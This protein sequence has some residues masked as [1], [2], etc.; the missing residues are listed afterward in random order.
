M[1][2]NGPSKK[3]KTNKQVK[4]NLQANIK[5]RNTVM[6]TPQASRKK[7]ESKTLNIESAT[8]DTIAET[9][10]FVIKGQLTPIK[11]TP[12]PV[13]SA[14]KFVTKRLQKARCCKIKD[15]KLQKSNPKPYLEKNELDKTSIKPSSARLALN[16]ETNPKTPTKTITVDKSKTLGKAKRLTKSKN[17]KDLDSSIKQIIKKYAKKLNIKNDKKHNVKTKN[18]ENK[19]NTSNKVVGRI[20]KAAKIIEPKTR[21][22]KQSVTI[23]GTS[24][25]VKPR[26]KYVKRKD[27]LKDTQKGKK[28]DENIQAKNNEEKKINELSEILPIKIKEEKVDEC[29]PVIVKVEADTEITCVQKNDKN[30]ISEVKLEAAVEH[31]KGHEGEVTEETMKSKSKLTKSKGQRDNKKSNTKKVRLVKKKALVSKKSQQQL[32]DKRRAKLLQFWNS[33]KRHRVASLNAI[34]KVHCLYENESKAAFDKMAENAIIKKE[35]AFGDTNGQKNKQNDTNEGT[36][37]FQS[38]LDSE[39]DEES[40][41]Q[42]VKRIL[43]DVPG[44]RAVG[45]HWDM[46]DSISSDNNSDIEFYR[47]P[48]KVVKVKKEVVPKKVEK[49]EKPK[50]T[51]TEKQKR[52]RKPKPEV[53][54]D[55]KD[56]VVKKRMASLNASAILAASYSNDKKEKPSRSTDSSSYDS[57]SSAEEYFAA[58]EQID[59]TN[60]TKEDV[61]QEDDRNLIEVHTTPNKK[62]AVILNQDTDVTITGVYVNSTT[63]STHHEGYCSIAGM[64]YRIS[65]TSHTQTAATAVATETLL[66]SSS[67]SDNVSTE[68]PYLT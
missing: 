50:K 16:K 20:S 62:V 36:T 68:L 55:L 58:I 49:A 45:K 59:L 46:H 19:S 23:V 43:R 9:I 28:V 32:E 41:E 17:R 13:A 4:T 63:R 8:K 39:S 21:T 56:M 26:K 30:V 14:T 57:D 54:M 48:K 15:V 7:K 51:D 12:L 11:P 1:T 27:E 53:Y 18:D 5:L 44:L 33:P 42:P 34:A 65:A 6:K 60:D 66:Q 40:D 24:S 47:I 37:T 22:R 38:I 35:P 10:A 61:K 67:S 29:F 2:R 31:A 52:R 3:R 64:Q 25:I